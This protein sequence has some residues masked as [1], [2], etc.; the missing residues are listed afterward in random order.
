[1]LT[2]DE[3]L[4]AKDEEPKPAPTADEFLD[5]PESPHPSA[6]Q[7]LDAPD[8]EPPKD[9]VLA[10]AGAAIRKNVYD[11]AAAVT[12]AAAALA[13]IGTDPESA[14]AWD[15]T[16]QAELTQAKRRLFDLDDKARQVG[17][18]MSGHL[19]FAHP[20]FGLTPAE[21]EEQRILQDKIGRL[22]RNPGWDEVAGDLRDHAN[23]SFMAY[24]VSPNSENAGA[25]FGR[26]IGRVISAAPFMGAG[27]P[28]AV[29][30][31]AGAAYEQALS[32]KQEE[33]KAA[34][35][36]DEDKI[37]SDSVLA[38]REAGSKAVASMG[39]Y[40]LGGKLAAGLAAKLIG[41]EASVAAKTIA[42][43]IGAAA[44]NVGTGSVLR[45]LEAPEGKRLGAAVP[46]IEN[47]TADTLFAVFHA[48]WEY[49]KAKEEVRKAAEAELK[50]RGFDDE[51]LKNTPPPDP[52]APAPAEELIT[53]EEQAKRSAAAAE[54]AR[55]ADEAR[56]AGLT[57]TADAIEKDAGV[58]PLPG[59]P[60]HGTAGAPTPRDAIPPAPA[61]VEAAAKAHD[62][63]LAA[64][65][66]PEIPEIH[67]PEVDLLRGLKSPIPP[68]PAAVPPS[69]PLAEPAPSN[70]PAKSNVPEEKPDQTTETQVYGKQPVPIPLDQL[71]LSADV[72]QFKKGANEKGVVE[73]LQGTFDTTGV[74]PIQVWRRKN[75]KLEIISGRH[76]FDLAQRSGEKTISSQ[77]HDEAA[78]FDARAA[79]RLD[80]ELNIRDENGSTADYA[81]YFRHS[82][83]SEEDASS[84]GLLG[85]AKGRAG[86]SI[87]RGA[88]EDV[89]ALH[90][91][92]KLSDQA[93]EA[94]SDAAPGND[95]AQRLGLRALRDGANISDAANAIRAAVAGFAGQKGEQG[96]FFSDT[97]LD[98]QWLKQGRV[99]SQR[100][101]EIRDDISAVRGAAN[102]LELAKKYG[103]DVQD[104]AGVQTKIGQLRA[105]LARWENW[106]QHPDLVAITR[107][108]TAPLPKLRG[109]ERQ[110]DLLSSQKENLTLVGESAADGD[111]IAAEKAA[112]EKAAADAKAEQD[113]NQ[114]DLFASKAEAPLNDAY[115]KLVNADRFKFPAVSIG[116][117]AKE[118]GVSIDT[119]KA[120]L[121][122]LH[123][124]GKVILSTGDW[125]LADEQT[126]AG[127]IEI[128]G[129]R[130]LQVR[131]EGTH[132][133]ESKTPAPPESWFMQKVKEAA[134]KAPT[135]AELDA[136][137]KQ[138]STVEFDR[139]GGGK[140]VSQNTRESLS[141][142][143][144]RFRPKA[145][146]SRVQAIADAV[147][148]I[149]SRVKGIRVRVLR[150]EADLPDNVRKLLDPNGI[151]EGIA[152][153]KNGDVYIFADNI[154]TP[155]RAA[156]VAAHEIIGHHG[157][158][159]I[160]DPEEWRSIADSIEKRAPKA[161]E[162][163]S[164]KYG[165]DRNTIAREYVARL[166]EKPLLDPSLWSKVVAGVRRG[167]RAMGITREWSEADIRDLIRR[168]AVAVEKPAP[169][170]GEGRV[171]A[172]VRDLGEEV[173]KRSPY[174]KHIEDAFKKIMPDEAARAA[175]E[176]Y[177]RA[178]LVKAPALKL[179]HAEQTVAEH[180][181]T[182][183]RTKAEF[184]KRNGVLDEAQARFEEAVKD[185][186]NLDLPERLA[187]YSSEVN[188]T[189]ADKLNARTNPA[190]VPE[191][192]PTSIKNAVVDSERAA[193]GMPP[194]MEPARKTF[195][196]T[197][198]EA[199][200]RLDS[201]HD[202]SRRLVDDLLNPNLK[203]K[204]LDDVQ[205]ALLL[206]RQITLQ[207][208]YDAAARATIDAHE[209]GDDAAA[210][211][212]RL[213]T[214]YVADELQKVY[215]A[216]K[217]A[218]TATGR[219]LNAR[220]MLAQSDYTLANM[221]VRKRAGNG[222]K[223]LSKEQKTE[224]EQLRFRM[225]ETE[226][227]IGEAE[228]KA[229]LTLAT[230]TASDA[231][232]E[233]VAK[234]KPA[235]KP[236]APKAAPEAPKTSEAASGWLNKAAEAAR[237]RIKDRGTRFNAGL[238][239]AD[240]ADRIIVGAAD[241]ASGIRDFSSWAAK[242][243]RE[244]GD[245]IRPHLEQVWNEANA[246]VARQ[247]AIAKTAEKARDRI[248]KDN[249]PLAKLRPY[250][251]KMAEEIV[252][253]GAT[254][255]P[256]LLD[257]LHPIV[258]GLVP[259]TTRRQTMDLFSGYGEFKP[260][261]K[262]AI[263]VQV[264]DLR[265]QAQQIGKIEDMQAGE[266]PKKTGV[267]RRD[268]S[269]KERAL[270]RE[271]ENLKKKGGFR[272]T[273]PESQLKTAMG[274]VK[275]RLKNQIRD[276]TTRFETG[277][278]P[279]DKTPLVYDHEA[280]VL[281]GIRDSI[282]ATLDAVEERPGVSDEQRLKAATDAIKRSISEYDRRLRDDDYA[283][284]SKKPRISSPEL[285]ALK[286]QRDALKAEFEELRELDEQVAR[287][288]AERRE[289][290]LEKQIQ[291]LDEKL[292][293]GDTSTTPRKTGEPS[294]KAADLAAER[295]AMQ[296]ELD[297]QRREANRKV[298][299]D[300][301][302]EAAAR[303]R[304]LAA[305][306]THTKQRIADFET[307][308]ANKDFSARPAR[309]RLILD[310]EAVK[311]KARLEDL[312]NSF[313][314]GLI[315]DKLANRGPVEK[316]LDGIA[317]WRRAFVLSGVATIGKL[318]SAAV[319][320]VGVSSIEELAGGAIG[321]VPGFREAALRGPRHGGFNM[322]A[323][324]KAISSNF[325][326]LFHDIGEYMR[327]GGTDFD[328]IYGQAH[329]Y[330]FE[331][332]E[333]IGRIH[334]ALK[335]PARR[336]E[337]TR[338]FEKRLAFLAGQG[339]DVTD[340]SI[341]Q[342]IAIDAY[343]DANRSIFMEDNMVVDAYKRALSLFSQPEK[344]T[345]KPSFA[346]KAAETTAKFFL[347]VVRIPTN[348]VARVFEYSLGTVTGSVRLAAAM[349]RGID[350]LSPDEADIIMRNM[351]RG[352]LGLAV[353]ALGYFNPNAVGGYYH[354]KRDEKDVK[355]GGLRL[356]G[357]DVPK[358]LIHNPLLEQLQIGATLRRVQ[359]TKVRKGS[360][361]T[362]GLGAG[363]WAAATGLIEETPFVNQMVRQAVAFTPH[364]QTEYLGELGK[365]V[366]P[367]IVPESANL[368]ERWTTGKVAKRNPKT[369][370]DRI[371]TAIP[372]L[373]ETVPLKKRQ[374]SR[375]GL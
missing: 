59:G 131:P 10:S 107:G 122:A 184:A 123:K 372:G 171:S 125:S 155:E 203:S 70:E 169:A 92:G 354:G 95:A 326:N 42:G 343:K 260:L 284:K 330:P 364:G 198:D 321:L 351:K 266:A 288:R 242:Q 25:R 269:D 137:G 229:D 275:T 300:A 134:A 172:A 146:G 87:A 225:D 166:A 365:S 116:E 140:I 63:I 160:L 76:R 176:E 293:T 282:R 331:W 186:P 332:K 307:R 58:T 335:T 102:K 310:P 236:K 317:K 368:Y 366:I 204:A 78:G 73:P 271:V 322:R 67:R 69:E 306:K 222:G 218:G 219:G 191:N 127:A 117:L 272:V 193:R 133:L 215:D 209:R 161:F 194:A 246:M 164:R 308:L 190:A 277:V 261:N 68:E 227:A 15:T 88:S 347:P 338:S 75:G 156:E 85:R 339:V 237:Q 333:M 90:Q 167:L 250:V 268:P 119:L 228:A 120:K 99:A 96:D 19:Q 328:K 359:D 344:D 28:V 79:A 285:T 319:E 348:I 4:D 238:D 362:A 224:L 232:K 254:E 138:P 305:Y 94:V 143:G 340:P 27:L 301:E 35:V 350:T 375:V 56:K 71:S 80:A 109:G 54:A 263:K 20:R 324:V 361:E 46:N 6:D 147:E 93:A 39:A 369:A 370:T 334:G 33:L 130:Y 289:A 291:A 189:V 216:G 34:G 311:Q 276:L 249:L 349:R 233:I 101:R 342:K 150:S 175:I 66:N 197:W 239:P 374:T 247:E 235:R 30:Q 245:A 178:K 98:D 353:M 240:L 154:S 83:I 165:S 253:G 230:E 185:K 304:S 108:E 212:G 1:M 213:R 179:D 196:S 270:I 148:G 97:G 316:T 74:A 44:S 170:R 199:M 200:Q 298:L 262:E 251:S 258:E 47:L 110:G 318:S 329:L 181:L 2:A 226:K 345:G 11:T 126:R 287:Q 136:T 114:G 299:T 38:G 281:K 360:R 358:L 201:D 29:G 279:P 356:F 195:G 100:Q 84:R 244:W 234:V 217:R 8:P 182:Y 206:H 337:F 124:A 82:D 57:A 177:V 286:A 273:D 303:K 295:D 40:M 357:W 231:V 64:G 7:F 220:K 320:I 9:G 341:Q 363:V 17:P 168:A 274:A 296:K 65:G 367:Q 211:E 297:R 162:E 149:K 159:R 55:L 48:Q 51:Q 26:G 315:A 180:F 302:K 12:D 36:T 336:N 278:K 49:S 223:P 151:H 183:F 292:K 115:Q 283:A 257:E 142:L 13:S 23:E 50:K 132:V 280:Q 139:P 265:G 32:A 3:F 86:F 259:G 371:K 202:A 207:N 128:G 45:A 16:K 312:R 294:S 18:Q 52:S 210:D 104:P 264:R 145:D 31:M 118:A 24:E 373:R 243:V 248:K 255:L 153:T 103:V 205:D 43:F 309:S 163:I 41:S 105:E 60:V 252:R 21:R 111:R 81:N 135:E 14:P 106:P 173:D 187:I 174:A 53:P 91:S 113:K 89:F 22:T 192:S 5:S 290:D 144:D 141:K 72:P 112:A 323:E 152:D 62:E 352:S 241:I 313:E 327:T 346:G 61:D 314:R 221:V 256:A 37:Y 129:D 267:Q 158:E 214:A 325:T 157:I 355:P 77:V 208:E 188:R 121:V